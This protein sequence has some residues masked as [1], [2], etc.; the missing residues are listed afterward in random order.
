MNSG[1]FPYVWAGTAYPG[2]LLGLQH[3]LYLGVLATL[4]TLGYL[5]I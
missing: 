2:L 1:M 3:L 4:D 5:A